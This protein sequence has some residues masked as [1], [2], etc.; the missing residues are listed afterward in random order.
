[1][2]VT[3]EKGNLGQVT[4]VEEQRPCN[5]PNRALPPEPPNEMPCKGI[6]ENVDKLKE[7]LINYYKTSA[8]KVCTHQNLPFVSSSPP[9]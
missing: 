6:E 3:N 8:L 2:E 5:Y 4:E 9:L 1:M 7:W